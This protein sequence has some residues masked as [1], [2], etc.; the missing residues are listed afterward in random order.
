MSGYRP[1][2]II[3]CFGCQNVNI[4]GIKLQNSTRF[5]VQFDNSEN[6]VCKGVT[7]RN[8]EWDLNQETDG[9][10]INS[11]RHVTIENAD[12][13]TGDDAVCLGSDGQNECY[14]ILVQDCTVATNCSATKIGTITP[15]NIYNV[16]FRKI[17]VN[18][19]PSSSSSCI[20]AISLQSN[21]GAAVH[22]ITCDGYTVNDCDTPILLAL[23]NRQTVVTHTSDSQLYNIA[24]KNIVCS[25]STRASQINTQEGLT[26]HDVILDNVKIYNKETYS[27]TAYPLYLNGIDAP[28][29]PDYG[30]LPAYGLFVRDTAALTIQSNV[31]F[32]D[33]GNSGRKAMVLQN[34]TLSRDSKTII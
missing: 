6:V 29:P 15:T 30:M 25:N 31:A 20:A 26:V 23:Q 12:I 7:I 19:V 17:T 16:T 24:L 32:Y 34:V 13:I 33:N 1:S 10:D 4:S 11:C 14:D 9:I 18:R 22:D 27:G 2:S 3:D 21:D 5:T 28:Y 8:R